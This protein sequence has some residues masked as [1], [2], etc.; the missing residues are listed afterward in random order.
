MEFLTHGLPESLD[1]S[2]REYATA[3]GIDEPLV[4]AAHA[5]AEHHLVAMYSDIQ[6]HSWYAH[7][8]ARRVFGGH[9]FELLRSKVAALG[10]PADEHLARRWRALE[11]C[12]AGSWGRAVFDFYIEH[13]FTFPGEPASI[14]VVGAE[15]DWVHVLAGY[16]TDPEG[17]IDVFGFIAGSM[18][19]EE[20]LAMFAS[21]LG[22]F[23]NGT[24]HRIAGEKIAIAT[25]DTLDLP[26]APDRL[27]EAFHRGTETT[28]DVLDL[29]HFAWRDV[30]LGD[31]RRQLNVAP[32]QAR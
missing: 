32:K 17:E 28:T 11:Q 15:H 27:A 19:N 8:T 7:E 10:G 2:V 3:L 6:R 13:G 21:T 14:R 26:G 29:D 1:A 4:R 5:L 22:L 20:G 18:G 9:V 12:P 30:G 24:I 25:A 31:A 16:E 23:Q